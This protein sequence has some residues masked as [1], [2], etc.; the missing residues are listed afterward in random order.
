MRVFHV[1]SGFENGGVEM[2][3]Y[4]LISHMS[5]D[6]E[7]HIVAHDVAV[8]ACMERLERLGVTVHIIPCRKQYFQHKRA[9]QAL[10]AEYRPA[11][12]HAHTTEWGAI[13]MRAAKRVGVACR[14]QHSHAARRE[15]NPVLQLFRRWCFWRARRT[16]THYF[17]CGTDAAVA[18]FGR[19]AVRE[20][21]VTVLKNGI[22]INAFAYRDFQRRAGR[23][24]LGVREDT[25]LVGMVARF[26]AQKNHIAAISLFAELYKKNSNAV[27]LLVGD[28]PLRPSVET[29][30]R[31][32]LP[33][34]AV[35]FLGVRHDMPSLYAAMD[36][37]I[38]PS[39]FEG[40][41]ITLIEAQTAG[42]PSV[43]SSTVT[44]EADFS[45]LVTFL[46]V[47]ETVRWRETLLAP[48]PSP[49]TSFAAQAKENGYSL[50]DAAHT[51]YEFYRAHA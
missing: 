40:L 5:R 15:K 25:L 8:P 49:R 47:R 44:R 11:V 23:A 18:A 43:V 4:R 46:D 35:R 51:L 39:R 24:A 16:A 36:R 27:L 14:I 21:R 29:L 41:P 17:A 19:R 26:S 37:F 30:A 45:G 2:L 50:A 3:L 34:E 1:I 42:L 12:V 33:K 32:V 22:D 6:I 10:F 7:F 28:G 20:G 31:R 9:L 48:L 13:A 38:L